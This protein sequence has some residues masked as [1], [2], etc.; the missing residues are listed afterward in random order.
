MRAALL[1]WKLEK[2]RLIKVKTKGAVDDC[3][4]FSAAEWKA[5]ACA[6]N[7]GEK[8]TAAPGQERRKY[9][10]ESGRRWVWDL[11]EVA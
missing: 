5:K 9:R 7:A 8:T 11:V 4:P 3:A 6:R 1:K 2:W 10:A